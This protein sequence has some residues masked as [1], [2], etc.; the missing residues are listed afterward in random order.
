MKSSVHRLKKVRVGVTLHIRDKGQSLWE[1][2]IFQ[3]CSFLVQLLRAC[4]NVAEAVLVVDTLEPV[5]LP[6]D[7]ML[8]TPGLKVLN[9]T[10][11]LEMTDVMI[12][13]SAQLPEDW[14]AAFRAKGGKYLWMRVGNDYVIDIE[15]AMHSLPH[16]GLCSTKKYDAVWTIPEY[17][18]SCH[19]YFSITAR[20]PVRILPHLWSPEFFDRG[21]SGL[22]PG[23]SYGYQP[24]RSRWRLCCFEPNVCTVKSGIIPLLACEEAYRATPGQIETVRI[25]NAISMKER[26]PF[27]EMA[28]SLDIV[29]HGVVSFEARYPLYDFMTHHG[30]CVVSHHW[31]NGQNYVYYE[32]LY[33]G[34]PLIHNSEFIKDHGYYYPDFD[35]KAAGAAIGKALIEHDANFESYCRNA[36]DL[37]RTL[38]PTY[39]DNVKAYEAALQEVLTQ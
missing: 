36:A 8:Q 18:R 14:V 17:E 13:M 4:S 37:I 33:G 34:Y 27:V 35:T 16:A 32:A 38:S 24:G 28:Q 39:P 12:E 21:I 2:G 9:L 19:D 20:A 3:N 1:N 5:I 25:C 31:E 26:K 7:M 22:P 11:A 30:D 6:P 29:K 23:S 10:E 15:R